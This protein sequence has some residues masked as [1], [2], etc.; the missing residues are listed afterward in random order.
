MV[1]IANPKGPVKLTRHNGQIHYALGHINFKSEGELLKCTLPDGITFLTESITMEF[2]DKES[3]VHKRIYI[4]SGERTV[5]VPVPSHAEFV[6]YPGGRADAVRDGIYHTDVK[7]SSL[8]VPP[9]EHPPE[10]KKYTPWQECEPAPKFIHQAPAAVSLP[11][12]EREPTQL[13]RRKNNIVARYPTG[14]AKMVTPDD[15]LFRVIYDEFVI[16]DN[17]HGMLI[18]P[19]LDIHCKQVKVVMEGGDTRTYQSNLL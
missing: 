11:E 2:Q 8:S 7:S 14:S 5:A 6:Y 18:I 12:P 3:G 10:P 19:S 4:D 17:G 9:L 15:G 16:E 1:L 13:K